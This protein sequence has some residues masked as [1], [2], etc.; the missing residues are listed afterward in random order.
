M[1]GVKGWCPGAYRPMM[2]GDGLIVRVRPHGG[3]LMGRQVTALAT[4]AN[5]FGNGLIDV[6]NRANLQVRGVAECDHEALLHGL[7]QADL[8][9]ID[10][11]AEARRN[12]LVQPFWEQGDDTQRLASELATRL[13]EL[14][15]LPA[16]FGFAIDAG[17]MRWLTDASAD[18]RIERTVE[19]ELMV[20]ADQA[21]RGVESDDPV[22]TLIEMAHW[23]AADPQGRRMATHLAEA[24]LP[25]HWTQSAPAPTKPVPLPGPGKRGALLG[26]PFGQIE[27]DVLATLA[28]GPIRVTPWRMLLAEGREAAHP[29]L[30]TRDDPVMRVDACPG[31]PACD[32]ATVSTRDIARALAGRVRGRLHVSG[33]AK[34]CARKADATVTLVGR[35]G[36]FDIVRGGNAQALPDHAGLSPD[37][38]LSELS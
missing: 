34:G 26:V 25:P 21:E 17:K 31:A 35:N 1:S 33:C 32:S 29:A 37:A 7:A 10:A 16:K 36:A 11:Q 23:Y 14:P 19:G 22:T 3:R 8:L 15:E 30:V 13:S 20:R 12:I 27:A 4:L 2:S 18:I 6:T 28:D 38:I 9:D 5:R 24:S